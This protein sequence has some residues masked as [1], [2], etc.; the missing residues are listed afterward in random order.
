M[1]V[2]DWSANCLLSTMYVEASSMDGALQ[3]FYQNCPEV[4]PIIV[5]I[6]KL[7]EN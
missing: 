3:A 6:T 4:N 5:D 2:I 1:Y 7:G